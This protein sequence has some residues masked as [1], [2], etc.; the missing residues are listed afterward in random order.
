LSFRLA[1]NSDSIHA[2]HNHHNRK[3]KETYA[4]ESTYTRINQQKIAI[5]KSRS[6]L[7][8]Y[9]FSTTSYVACKEFFVCY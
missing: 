6:N 8:G 9:Y 2:L 3:E 5:Q 1:E 7:N 4:G